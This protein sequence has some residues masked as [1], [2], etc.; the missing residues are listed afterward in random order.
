MSDGSSGREDEPLGTG[1]EVEL[2]TF[3]APDG[4]LGDVSSGFAYLL[5]MAAADLAG[6]PLLG[7]VHPEDRAAVTESVAGLAHAAGES[8][9]ECR[10]VQSD[11]RAVYV[12]WLARPLPGSPRWQAAGLDA[13]DFVSL[14]SEQ[15]DLRTRLD[16]AIGQATAATWDLD[17]GEGRIGWEAQAAEILSVSPADLPRDA[18]ALA[19]AVHAADRA[20]VLDAFAR[21]LT[22]GSTDVALRIG[23]EPGLRHLSLRGRVIDRDPSGAPLRAVGLLLDV[24]TE[25]AM[26]EQLLRMSVS[27]ALTGAPNR[28][29]FD[30]AL[31]GE[32][33]RC[34]RA[35]D[36]LSLIMIDIDA[37][38]QFNDSFGHLVGDQAL[39]AV[40]RAMSAVLQREGDVLARYGGEEFAVVLPGTDHAGA[41]TVGQRLLEAARAVTVRQAPGWKLSVSVGTA[42]WHPDREAIKAPELLGRADQALYAAKTT[43]KDR[44][45][46]YEES[47]AARDTLHTAIT[48]GLQADEFELYYQPIIRLAD[49]DVVGFEALMRWNRPGHGLV[50]PDRFIPIAETTTLICDLGRWALQQAA[51]QVAIWN[52]Q[53][54]RRQAP[55]RVA[56]N[57]SARHASTPMILA[58]VTSAL[59]DA[60]ITPAQLIL[61]LTETAL[62]SRNASQAH[63]TQL[64]A[65]GVIVSIDDFGTGY[66]SIGD[67]ASL[68][69]DEL[70]ID[71]SFVASLDPRQ[72]ALVT[73]MIEAAHA[74]DLRVVAEGIE[75]QATLDGL[76][77][78]GCDSAQGYHIARPMPAQDVPAW[79][80]SHSH[81]RR[82]PQRAGPAA[83]A[84]LAPHALE[85]SAPRRP[86]AG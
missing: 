83:A 53:P 59:A 41:L 9:I 36:P 24:S 51:G 54:I 2:F 3:G 78:L 4:C 16:L 29:A 44:V 20:L 63:L 72:R 71:R 81:H 13:T 77:D 30:Q 68:P 46:A 76:R 40:A 79:L 60:T 21:L 31:R 26:E 85:Y 39:I 73:L 84:R 82:A 57:I 52:E 86:P 64:R 45:I 66:T 50:S 49:G 8:L 23:E 37:F 47:L 55:L 62:R 70:K 19:G 38:K 10:F 61:E 33:R 18:D 74:F 14:L 25:K 27:D 35:R 22:D 65:L 80:D 34:T 7:C 75:D 32:W 28:R 15:R 12:R 56:V 58:D 5:G 6:R 11:G 69:A 42:S 67:Y 17:V 48:A 43:G 1:A